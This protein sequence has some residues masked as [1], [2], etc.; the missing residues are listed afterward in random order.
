MRLQAAEN[1]TKFLED[2]LQAA[3]QK[4]REQEERV[5]A[6]KERHPESGSTVQVLTVLRSEL[7]KLEDALARQVTETSPD[8]GAGNTLPNKQVLLEQELHKLRALRDELRLRFIDNYPDV[9][10]VTQEIKEK[11]KVLADLKPNAPN[12][13]YPGRDTHTQ[14][15][16]GCKRTG[17]A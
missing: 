9:R 15:S 14:E 3:H 7:Q 4:L 6:F 1:T 2:Q 17:A 16:S 10:E 12:S 5:R 8:L 13:M 11:E